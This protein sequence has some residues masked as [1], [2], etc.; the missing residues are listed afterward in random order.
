MSEMFTRRRATQAELEQG[1]DEMLRVQ[2]RF[3]QD[4]EPELPIE[5]VKGQKEKGSDS[6]TA[7]EMEKN[8]EVRNPE[9]SYS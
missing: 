6:P 1:M 4:L 3:D 8:W 5:D 2:Q 9:A 7:S